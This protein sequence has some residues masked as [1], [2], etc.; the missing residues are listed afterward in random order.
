MSPFST[1]CQQENCVDINKI[2]RLKGRIRK[3]FGRTLR[4]RFVISM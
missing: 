4:K 3:I 1:G 2:S